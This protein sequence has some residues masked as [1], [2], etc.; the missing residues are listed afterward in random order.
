M[1]ARELIKAGLGSVAD[2]ETNKSGIEIVA[3]DESVLLIM[4]HG[5]YDSDHE[6]YNSDDYAQTVALGTMILRK[7]KEK[8][9]VD[10]ASYNRYAWNDPVDLPDWFVDDENKHHRPQLPIPPALLAKMKEKMA[11]LSTKPIKK[12]AEARARKSKRAKDKLSAAKK[13]AE[14]VAKATEMT[15]SMKLKAISKALRVQ[16]TK[17]PGKTYV[18]AKK[19]CQ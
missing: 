18:V 16:A 19:T 14:S 1:D 3:K 7:S 10:D 2:D 15:E 4:D 5:K 11:A 17:K 13:K 6:D 9:L 8:A 12:V